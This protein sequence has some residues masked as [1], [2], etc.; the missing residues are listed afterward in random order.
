MEKKVEVKWIRR[1]VMIEECESTIIIP[2]HIKDNQLNIFI[3]SKLKEEKVNDVVFERYEE[4]KG[5]ELKEPE[6]KI[7]DININIQESEVTE[8]LKIFLIRRTEEAGFDE[9][10]EFVIVARNVHEVKKIASVNREDEMINDWLVYSI[11]KE[12]G[13]YAGDETEPHVVCRNFKNA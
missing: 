13:P 11:V 5:D 1:S 4:F 8:P 12:L 10:Q 9:V 2:E 6:I 3:M 7:I